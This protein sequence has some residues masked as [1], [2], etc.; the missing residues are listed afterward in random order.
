MINIYLLESAVRRFV[1]RASARCE[2][3]PVLSLATSLIVM[4]LRITVDVVALSRG[5]DRFW[6]LPR[7][8]QSARSVKSGTI[9]RFDVI[10]SITSSRAGTLALTLNKE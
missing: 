1:R 8:S 9:A 4:S 2:S 6:D 3:G 10:E 7:S 5:G